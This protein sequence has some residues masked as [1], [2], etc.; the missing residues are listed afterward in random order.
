MESDAVS[1]D[2]APHADV[3]S[4]SGKTALVTGAAKRL[5]RAMAE[6][7][8]RAGANLVLHYHQSRTEAEAL[9]PALAPYG[10][11][12]VLLQADLTKPEEAEGLLLRAVDAAGPVDCLVNNASGF[13]FN[14][15]RDVTFAELSRDMALSAFAPLVLTRSMVMA[16][17]GGSVVN[18]LDCRMVDYD[19]KHVSYHLA[20]RS[21]YALTRM[22]AE[23]FA[24]ELRVN[25]VAPGIILP[26]EGEGEPWLRHMRK[27]NPLQTNG[28]PEQVAQAVLFLLSQ[29]FITGQVIFVDG[30]RHLR[31]QFY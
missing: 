28:T 24:P 18:L 7:L 8:A 12:T 2:A 10:V 27:T 22:M 14:T 6:E 11:K 19:S 29:P 5:G 9:L 30:G 16:G 20:K 13:A 31:G 21:L 3:P 26:P 23:E 25:A 1:P 4:L 17:Q 15:L